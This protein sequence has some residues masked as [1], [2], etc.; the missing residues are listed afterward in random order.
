MQ[1]AL[2]KYTSVLYFKIFRSIS[3]QELRIQQNERAHGSHDS[4][5][6]FKESVGWLN[7]GRLGAGY[8]LPP[9]NYLYFFIIYIFTITNGRL[10]TVR[11]GKKIK[12]NK[13]LNKITRYWKL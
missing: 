13:K 8:R 3:N 10:K 11:H 2:I 6:I 1:C 9:Q 7:I 5:Q 12:Q 4:I